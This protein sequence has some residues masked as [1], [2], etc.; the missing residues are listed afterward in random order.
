[1]TAYN[2]LT[3]LGTA[4]KSPLSIERG[5]A[6]TVGGTETVRQ[7]IERLLSTPK[8]SVFFNRAY[9]S[10]LQSLL[11][12]T[13]DAVLSGLIQHFILEAIENFEPRVKFIDAKIDVQDNVCRC[14]IRY[15]ILASNEIDSLIYPFYRNTTF[16]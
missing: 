5:R 2:N 1:M 15:R 16:Q 10:R 9:G 4:L 12:E 3:Y 6:L 7:A 13:N 11:F 8:G 14:F